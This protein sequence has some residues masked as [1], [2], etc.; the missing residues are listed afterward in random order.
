MR[1][2]SKIYQ[3][4][5]TDVQSNLKLSI[6][7]SSL[8]ESPLI[9]V[10]T[11]ASSILSSMSS[12]IRMTV[13]EMDSMSMF[14][15]I[16][17]TS[18]TPVVDSTP[19]H[20]LDLRHSTVSS[21]EHT[22]HSTVHKPAD[23][24]NKWHSKF[25]RAAEQ[26]TQDLQVR[27][28]DI[29]ARESSPGLGEALL[30]KLTDEANQA[31][32]SVK[33]SIIEAVNHLPEEDNDE[34]K[35]SA[36]HEVLETLRASGKSLKDRAQEVRT[37][38]IEH[39]VE[40]DSLVETAIESTMSI[41]DGIRDL[42]LQRIGMTWS[43]SDSV[44]YEDWTAY[45]NLKKTFDSLR[46]DVLSSA[47]DQEA[48]LQAKASSDEVQNNAMTVAGTAAKELA[49]LKDVARWKIDASDASN[50]FE[51]RFAP[52]AAAKEFGQ[53]VAGLFSGEE[54]ESDDSVMGSLAAA[55]SEISSSITETATT[56]SEHL[57]SGVE[58]ITAPATT[59]PSPSTPV[60][61]QASETAE[62]V[63]GNVGGVLSSAGTSVAEAATLVT[64]PL[65]ASED[66]VSTVT[67]EAIHSIADA[68]LP[69]I[70]HK[71]DEAGAEPSTSVVTPAIVQ[72]EPTNHGTAP[73][74]EAVDETI[75]EDVKS[76][77]SSSIPS[78]ARASVVSVASEASEVQASATILPSAVSDAFPASEDVVDAAHQASASLY[79]RISEAGTGFADMTSSLAASR[80]A[81]V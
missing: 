60:V 4:E 73:L 12:S 48:L 35:T 51:S 55:G 66:T 20:T 9:P 31:V 36:M 77:L 41:L 7:A 5:G 34:Q 74:V 39:D 25:T 78:S 37:W 33:N 19:S 49:R 21:A 6:S 42:G 27:V 28:S 45:H 13:S 61:S 59:V 71:S 65:S 54:N 26:A 79:S 69:S 15:T 70:E 3:L 75:P 57:S 80:S 62:E 1:L 38:K 14:E 17:P 30:A 24:I 23:D 32:D 50:D 64:S 10:P 2:R 16:V 47:V 76:D 11:S 53:K 56:I 40:I 46:A 81:S 58:D 8:A 52:V 18:T 29:I 43:D 44:T 63:L 67:S 68:I 22:M 72:E